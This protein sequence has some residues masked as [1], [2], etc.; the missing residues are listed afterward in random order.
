[1]TVQYDLLIGSMN[2]GTQGRC[3]VCYESIEDN[4]IYIS[5]GIEVCSEKCEK[6]FDKKPVKGDYSELVTSGPW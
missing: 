6:L 2:K 4:S 5:M 3:F 1:M